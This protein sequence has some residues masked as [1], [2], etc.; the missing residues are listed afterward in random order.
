MKEHRIVFKI[1]DT[2]ELAELPVQA[3]I[4]ALA[5]VLPGEITIVSARVSDDTRT[6]LIKKAFKAPVDSAHNIPLTDNL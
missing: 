1:T 3:C 5:Q 2:V 4:N 6:V